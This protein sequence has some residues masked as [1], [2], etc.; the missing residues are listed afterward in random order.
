M[1][2]ISKDTKG[3]RR[4]MF[5]DADGRRKTL[6]LGRAPQRAADNIK[7][8]VESIVAAR[9]AGV[10]WDGPTAEWVAS[11]ADDLA[12]KLARLGL[13]PVRER[14]TLDQFLEEYRE[15]RKD[16]KGATRVVWRQASRYLVEF[17]GADRQ[18]HTIS[19]GD[20]DDFR[21][22]LISRGLAP[23]TI[24]KRL[25]FARQFFRAMMRRGLIAA[26]PFA[27]VRAPAVQDPA[28]QRFIT[29]EET[30]SLLEACPN[31]TWR[32]IIGLSRFGGL[33]CPSEVLSLKWSDV[34]WERNR[35]RVESPKT[36]HHQGGQSRTV[37]IFP[38][39][40]PILREA[41]EAAEPGTVYVVDARYRIAAWSDEG[42]KNCNLRTQFNR[43]VKRAG[44]EPWPRLF[45]NMRASRETELAKQHPIHVVTA[46]LGN[47]PKIALRHYLQ[48]TEADYET[49]T[50]NP[51]QY[52][53]KRAGNGQH[54]EETTSEGEKKGQAVTTSGDSALRSNVTAYH[55]PLLLKEI[56]QAEGTGL[57]Q[58]S[59]TSGKA[60]FL[61]GGN[62]ES[63]AAGARN[64]MP[65][66]E[67]A[68]IVAAWPH[69][70]E[71]LRRSILGMI[72]ATV[73]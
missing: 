18:V 60:G 23:T 42:W 7:V 52:T 1:A 17:F 48:V 64:P 46:W 69:L 8:R 55:K 20:A 15:R 31:Y 32:T 68:E 2:S 26:N 63:D 16:V 24:H 6:Y 59:K 65:A 13:I 38:E 72:R 71:E 40:L 4:L 37:P 30:T 29:R 25:Q 11:L 45:H 44:L 35:M 10:A 21:V 12:D 62:A 34:D 36:E 50:Q 33:R 27:E 49:A 54:G 19:P 57:E 58:G 41:W 3:N 9:R 51:T 67:L 43:I 66:G 22:H 70:P 14:A 61:E 53:S 73:G 56:L 5:V 39:L 47:T 28:R